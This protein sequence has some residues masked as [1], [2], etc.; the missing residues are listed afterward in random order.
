MFVG[1]DD[2]NLYALD[3]TTGKQRWKFTT[4]NYVDSPPALNS[5]TVFVGSDDNNLYAI[6]IV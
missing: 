1:S 6:A 3:I 4:G 2:N 5:D